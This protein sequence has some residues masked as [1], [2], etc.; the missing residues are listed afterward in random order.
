MVRSPW[1]PIAGEYETS[2]RKARRPDVLRLNL[3]VGVTKI[4]QFHANHVSVS[5]FANDYYQIMFEAEEE[6]DDPGS[7]YLLIQRQFE[8]PDDDLCYVEAHDEKY[9]GHFVL[10]RVEFTLRGLTIELDRTSDNRLSVTFT[11]APSE[12]NEASQVMKI[13]SGEIEPG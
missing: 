9:I 5:T 6:A 10:R 7:P 8:D 11:M 13:I 2:Y 1:L 4:M 3:R 12:F